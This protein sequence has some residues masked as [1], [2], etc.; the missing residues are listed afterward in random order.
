MKKKYPLFFC[1]TLTVSL[2]GFLSCSKTQTNLSNQ[3]DGSIGNFTRL[4]PNSG[5]N[6]NNVSNINSS[7]IELKNETIP[8]YY[9]SFSYNTDTVY[10]GTS[11]GAVLKL[12]SNYNGW[13]QVAQDQDHSPIVALAGNQDAV[14]YVPSTSYNAYSTNGN[15]FSISSEL[16]HLSALTNSNNGSIYFGTNL[17]N[18]GLTNNPADKSIPT[19][20][21]PE[22]GPII[23]LSCENG[24]CN[25]GQQGGLVFQAES[26]IIPAFDTS[27]FSKT[28]EKYHYSSNVYY[29]DHR[30]WLAANYN[31]I[32]F[33]DNT[34]IIDNTTYEH[35]PEFVTFFTVN[36][37]TKT[38]YAGTNFF[39]IY[40]ANINCN[41]GQGCSIV[42][43]NKPLNTLPLGTISNGTQGITNIAIL[44]DGSLYVID[45]QSNSSILNVYK[46]N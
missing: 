14:L 36:P 11:N 15:G 18:V 24:S 7:K 42:W 32:I 35:V 43:N 34:V 10:T 41:H 2:L 8:I 17:G 13:S 28:P 44:P 21:Y 1:I 30:S 16:G 9:T 19:L 31:N 39:N 3:G 4:T 26:S 6:I 23:T 27:V 45:T 38:A 33:T 20:P 5:V 22:F 40:T 12:N 46:S 25:S 37:N 29:L